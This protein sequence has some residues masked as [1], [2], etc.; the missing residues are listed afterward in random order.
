VA[1]DGEGEHIRTGNSF[2]DDTTTGSTN[3]D[4]ELEPVSHDISDLT[5]SEEKL[6]AKMEEIIQ[7]FLD[8]LQVTGGDLA[9]KKCVWYLISHRWKDGEPRLL[10][11][12]S[13]HRGV[14]IVSRSTNTESGVKR[15]APNESNHTLVLF[16]TGDRTCTAQKKVMTEN[17]SLYATAIQ[18]SSVWKGKSGLAY[19][20]FYLP[21]I[22]Y[23]TPATTLTQQECY[24]IQ[25]PVVNAIFPKMGI[26]RKAHRS[27]VFGAARFGGLGLEHL[28]SYQGHNRLQYVMG[29]LCYNSTTGKLMRSMLD[30]TQLECVC[31]GNVL[32]ED[33]KRYSRILMTENWI[34]GI[35]EHLHSCKSTLKIAAEWKLLPNCKN[36]VVMMEALTKTEEFTATELKEINRCRI[37]LR[38]FYISAIA[39]H[40]GQ[41]ISDWAIKG[42]QDAGRKSSLAWP[43]QQRPTS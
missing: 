43:V 13:S 28:A 10:Q 22:G 7:F 40:D 5:S 11:K 6:I 27:V 42:R 23:G 32:E 1:I 26:S 35:W 8:L 20:S 34:N 16:M 19:N 37:Y 9:P 33:Y 30:Y 39:S 36:D 38:V 4:S 14:K 25:T 2:I 24:N 21:L 41:G 17:A 29:H 12:H 31:L 3:D 15:K 18:R